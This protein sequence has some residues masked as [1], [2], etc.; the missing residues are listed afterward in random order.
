MKLYYTPMTCALS[1]HIALEE[2]GADYETQ[3]INFANNE[4]RSPEFLAINPK[5]R[6]PVL[7][8]DQGTLTET[9][10]MLAY[11]AQKFPAAK[12]A[13]LDDLFKFAEVQSV[14]SYLCSTVHVAHAHRVRGI[15]WADDEQAHESMKKKAPQNMADSCKLIEEQILKGPYIM[16]NDFSISDIYLNTICRWLASDNVEISD[17]PNLNA[18]FQLVSER[19]AVKKIIALHQ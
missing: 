11:I 13:P 9:P 18:H 5:G 16:G 17:Y 19:P 2:S 12:L 4:Q 14:N 8:T 7:V 3:K 10:A 6:V 15:R 1:V